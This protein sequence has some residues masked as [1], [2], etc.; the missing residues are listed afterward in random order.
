MLVHVHA[1]NMTWLYTYDSG[2]YGL[3]DRLPRHAHNWNKKPDAIEFLVLYVIDTVA[4]NLSI[5]HSVIIECICV[6]CQHS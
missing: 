4:N 1:F 3:N 2:M 5:A 6:G